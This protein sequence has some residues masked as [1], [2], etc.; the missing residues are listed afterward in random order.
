MPA[1]RCGSCGGPSVDGALCESC[2]HAFNPLLAAHTSVVPQE[3]A[4]VLSAAEEA[5]RAEEAA[6]AEDAAKAERV[7]AD[8]AKAEAAR[9]IAASV[10]AD[11]AA[12]AAKRER[13]NLARGPRPVVVT[14]PA[15]APSRSPNRALLF[16]IAALAI[17]GAAAFEQRD[18]LMGLVKT[19]QTAPETQAAEL[20]PALPPARVAATA[21]PVARHEPVAAPPQALPPVRPVAVAVAAAKPKAVVRPPVKPVPVKPVPVKLASKPTP[22]PAKGATLAAANP[23]TAAVAPVV[24]APARTEKV[25]TAEVAAPTGRFFEPNDVD[26]APKV[27]RRIEPQLPADLK[28]RPLNDIVIV[29]LLVSQDG[30]PSHVSL[31][32]KSKHGRS[33]DNAV[34]AAVTQWSFSPARKKGEAVSSWYNVGVP[35]SVN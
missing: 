19:A 6:K 17:A 33:L 30:D 10:I 15:P 27:A 5:V 4:P 11:R 26:V 13:E 14:P 35:L 18:Y 28:G 31:L 2:Q 9:K 16:T 8:A 20:M 25:R 12:A 22:S 21:T 7:K 23:S 3:E 32:R 34:I 24:S 29:R 1:A